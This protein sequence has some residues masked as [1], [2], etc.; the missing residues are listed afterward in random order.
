MAAIW[1]ASF[2]LIKVAV[3]DI[4]PLSVVAGR[5]LLG[6]L[7]LLP[8]L[9]LAG[10]RLPGDGRIWLDFLVVAVVGNIG[11]FFLIAWAELE[12]DSALA[13]ILMGTVPIVAVLLAHGLTD[14]EKLSRGKLL[15]VLLGLGG[16]VLLV[17]PEALRGLGRGLWSQLAIVAAG[18]GYAL[19]GIYAR[20]RGLTRLPPAVIACGVLIAASAVIVP[21]ALLLD[22]PWRLAPGAEP[23]L[24]LLG[25]G[26]VST[27]FA[28]IILFR[29][30][31]AAGVTFVALNNYLVPPFGLFWGFL[32]L[33]EAIPSVA[34]AAL[35]L[36]LAGVALAQWPLQPAAARARTGSPGE[37]QE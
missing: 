24:A 18:C 16:V 28:Y 36:I 8:I 22:R 19:S 23:L 21:I 10:Q 11:P 34:L 31:A 35:G 14:D 26:L 32:I 29:L 12:I 4:P 5:I 15:G 20:R 6:C 13:A 33:G 17:G 30:L 1:G 25:L 3:Q 7:A 9:L 2:F 37:A 27:G